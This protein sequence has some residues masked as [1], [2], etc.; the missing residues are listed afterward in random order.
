MF[1]LFL[2]TVGTSFAAGLTLC[3][4]IACALVLGW[5]SVK[6]LKIAANVAGAD[7]PSTGLLIGTIIATAIANSFVGGILSFIGLSNPIF[8]SLVGCAVCI[9]VYSALLAGGN[10][11]Q[12]VMIWLVSTG[13]WF[14][15]AACIT[16]LGFINLS[17]A[18]AI[19]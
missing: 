18:G 9:A 7:N 11:G 17:V 8:L 14:G 2:V 13:L 16:L 5:L 4:G 3:A 1:T 15:L 19:F 12:G 10:R 6:F